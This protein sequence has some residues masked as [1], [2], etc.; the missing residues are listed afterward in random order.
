MLIK[1]YLDTMTGNE[2]YDEHMVY[3]AVIEFCKKRNKGYT[4]FGKH[5]GYGKLFMIN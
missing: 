3:E 5:C 1:K 4:E 2:G